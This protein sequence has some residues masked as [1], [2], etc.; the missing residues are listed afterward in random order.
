MAARKA[1]LTLWHDEF[2]AHGEQQEKE[3]ERHIS[4]GPESSFHLTFCFCFVFS[5]SLV[6][7]PLFVVPFCLFYLFTQSSPLPQATRPYRLLP[8]RLTLSSCR[9]R[10]QVR[11][12]IPIHSPLHQLF[13]IP[14][15]THMHLV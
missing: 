6:F 9:P 2:K 7:P 4:L 11:G 13:C 10:K 8:Q 15:L 3:E 14:E 12:G 1:A 5:P